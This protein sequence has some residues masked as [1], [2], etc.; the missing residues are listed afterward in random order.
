MIQI[1]KIHCHE[2]QNKE[3]FNQCHYANTDDDIAWRL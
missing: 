2:K 1:L 3:I